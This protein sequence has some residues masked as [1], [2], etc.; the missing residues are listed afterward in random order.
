MVKETSPEDVDGIHKAAGILTSTVA[1]T[2]HAAVVARGWGK[3]CVAGAG[4][5]HID[6]K[7][8][9]IVV[10]KKKFTQKD[11][12]SIDGTGGTTQVD[13]NSSLTLNSTLL[14]A[15]PP[16]AIVLHCLPAYRGVEITDDVLD[17]P[18]SRVFPQA[19]NRLHAQKGLLAVL[20]G[21]A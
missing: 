4:E 21:G 9:T 19:H 16:A 5:I 15:A 11:T 2:S 3:C 10:G 20:M 1:M 14:D 6:E 12:I 18:R 8:K 17:G 7:K 13:L